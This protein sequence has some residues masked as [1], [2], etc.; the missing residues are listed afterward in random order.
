MG[1]VN[2]SDTH[3]KSHCQ[4]F[5]EIYQHLQAQGALSEDAIFET[6]QDMLKTKLEESRAARSAAAAEQSEDINLLS[7]FKEASAMEGKSTG[8]SVNLSD[9]FKA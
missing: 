7:D 4:Q 8:G 9:I 2:L 6:A 3:N 1:S 5:I